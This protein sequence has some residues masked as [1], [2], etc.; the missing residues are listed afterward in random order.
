MRALILLAG[1]LVA[2]QA[3][4]AETFFD[5]VAKIAK[6]AQAIPAGA[7]PSV[8]TPVAAELEAKAKTCKPN[9]LPCER[10]TRRLATKL[11]ASLQ[12]DANM[13]KMMKE[14]ARIAQ[15]E[16]LRGLLMRQLNS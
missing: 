14:D 4:A 16:K 7:K 15:I 8:A 10:E 3:I 6:D 12:Q 13:A 9:D 2:S 5:R 11:D 1:L